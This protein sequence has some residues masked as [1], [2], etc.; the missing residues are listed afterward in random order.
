MLD[1]HFAQLS[2]TFVY[3]PL[4]V[5]SPVGYVKGRLQSIGRKIRE[6]IPVTIRKI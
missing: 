6:D 2:V 3:K 4:I 5:D 1:L